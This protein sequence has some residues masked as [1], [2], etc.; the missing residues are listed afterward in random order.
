VCVYVSELT[1][2]TEARQRST[3]VEE[4]NGTTVRPDTSAADDVTM[5]MSSQKPRVFVEN[6]TLTF[7]TSIN[8][9]GLEHFTEYTVKVCVTWWVVVVMHKVPYSALF[10][11][12]HN[13]RRCT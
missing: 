9:T 10:I 5:V 11:T 2:V 6:E 12:F 4:I 3:D 8:I 7:S 1:A 13:V